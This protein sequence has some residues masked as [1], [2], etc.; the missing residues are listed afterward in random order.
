MAKTG[1]VRQLK[2]NGGGSAV[3]FCKGAN[4]RSLGIDHTWTCE[5][6]YID[7]GYIPRP[8]RE[9]RVVYLNEE[10]SV[11]IECPGELLYSTTFAIDNEFTVF[12]TNTPPVPTL[13]PTSPQGEA[14]IW[15]DPTN[16]SALIGHTILVTVTLSDFDNVFGSEVYISFNPSILQVI[17]ADNSL[18]GVQIIPGKNLTSCPFADLVAQ[19]MVVNDLGTIDYA[20]TQLNPRSPCTDGD[21]AVIEFQC[22]SEGIS[23][24][25]FT[26]TI[27]SDPDGN[28]IAHNNQNSLVNCVAPATN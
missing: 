27:I 21:M 20:A 26:N 11:H 8:D 10:Q 6:E 3:V 22:I 1:G 7:N 28:P 5:G 15:L 25:G 4:I 9:T 23:A 2:L 14:L 12:C 19:N 13:M 24:V 18:P 16:N 17:D